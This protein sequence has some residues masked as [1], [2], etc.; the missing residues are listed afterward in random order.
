MTSTRKLYLSSGDRFN[1]DDISASADFQLNASELAVD[2]PSQA[3]R[4]CLSQASLPSN[5]AASQSTTSRAVGQFLT[6]T[7]SCA[8]FN[9]FFNKGGI[10]PPTRYTL[11]FNDVTNDPPPANQFS[12]ALTVQTSV[13]DILDGMNAAMDETADPILLIATEVEEY[14]QFRLKFVSNNSNEGTRKLEAITLGG[15]TE[16]KRSVELAIGVPNTIMLVNF[17]ASDVTGSFPIVRTTQF[18][19]NAA[20]LMPVVYITSSLNTNTF[21][22]SEGLN[23]VLASV[24]LRLEESSPPIFID[25]TFPSDGVPVTL[26]RSYVWN[27]QPFITEGSHKT[28]PNRDISN[29]S[30]QLR[31][32]EGFVLYGGSSPFSVVLEVQTVDAVS[33]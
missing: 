30:I 18:D 7:Q 23:N 28:I 1:L 31:N 10:N 32:D 4:V 27:Y 8:S 21:A 14:G 13:Q 33:S 22:T 11:F 6:N 15:S 19:Y 5:L 26:L 9:W 24:P 20:L 29:I 25:T 12:M 3:F 2:S 17:A 16:N